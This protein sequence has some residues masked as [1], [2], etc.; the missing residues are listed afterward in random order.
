MPNAYFL[1]NELVVATLFLVCLVHAARQSWVAVARLTAGVAFGLLLELATIR[2]LRAYHYGTFGVMVFDVPL[3]VAVAWGSIAYSVMT[4][5]DLARLP[6]WAR[7]ILDGL[8]ALNIDLAMD[9]VAI[10]MGMWDW[11][12]GLHFNYFGV[13]YA[14]FW[15]WFWVIF[16]FSSGYRLAAS[17][18]TRLV[19][20][21]APLIAVAVG[22]AGVLATNALIAFAV[23]FRWHGPLVAATLISALIVVL[24]Q[25]VAWPPASPAPAWAVPLGFHLY[26]LFAGL[27]SGVIFDPPFLLLVSVL[28]LALAVALHRPRP[29]KLAAGGADASRA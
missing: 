9:A 13:P 29:T 5:S 16:F 26:F 22:L 6:A 3:M 10:R 20:T 27:I 17:S 28:M 4:F 7:P 1:V 11:G 21:L 19:R 23:P 8:L 25:R 14:N 12:Q 24:G 15:A 2:Q 18:R